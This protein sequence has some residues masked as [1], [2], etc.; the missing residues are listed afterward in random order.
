MALAT[1]AG[2]EVQRPLATVVVSGI[3]FS[4]LLTMFILPGLLQLLLREPSRKPR[5]AAVPESKVA[6]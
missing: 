5:E 6:A 2:A 4:T 3:A 1:G